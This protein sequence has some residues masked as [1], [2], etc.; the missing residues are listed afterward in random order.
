VD[1]GWTSS[2]SWADQLPTPPPQWYFNVL[3]L[4][5]NVDTYNDSDLTFCLDKDVTF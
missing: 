3:D 1:G 2:Q 5:R 4:A